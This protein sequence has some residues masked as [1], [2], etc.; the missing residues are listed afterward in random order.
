M[1]EGCGEPAARGGISITCELC[2]RCVP[3]NPKLFAPR[4]WVGPETR[5]WL[6]LLKTGAAAFLFLCW[7]SPERRD[8][9]RWMKGRWLRC[10]VVM[11]SPRGAGPARLSQ[12]KARC[13]M[14]LVGGMK[15]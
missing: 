12:L 10:F 11:V 13:I 1:G 9:L 3:I 5:P 8:L 4:N 7:L 6:L 2:A 15:E 14:T